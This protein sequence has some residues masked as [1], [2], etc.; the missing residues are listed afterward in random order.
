VTAAS[1]GFAPAVGVNPHHL[2]AGKPATHG[3]QQVLFNC[4]VPGAF[5]V[6]CFG[7]DQIRTAYNIQPLLDKGVT[8]KGRTI[9]IIDAFNPPNV[10]DELD[11]FTDT[12]GLPKTHLRVVNPFGAGYDE[13]DPNQ[14]GWSGE[15]ALDV[16]WSH[17]V[18]PDAK[19]VLVTA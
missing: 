11:T 7:P 3:D 9:V 6:R 18:A 12:W 10:Q 17:V 14:Q 5:V 8:G 1:S 2:R 13:T 16:E 15:I 4:Q 19:L